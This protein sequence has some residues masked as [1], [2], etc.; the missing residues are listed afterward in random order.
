[1][2]IGVFDSGIGG[3]TVLAELRKKFPWARFV[4]LGDTANV[5]YGTKSPAQVKKLSVEC[6]KILSERQVHAAVIACNTASS[7]AFDEIQNQFG[8]TPVY[9]VLKPG[10]QAIMEAVGAK[11]KD[12]V[13]IL[14]TKATIRSQGYVKALKQ[15]DPKLNILEQACPL[16]VPMIEEGWV[17]HPILHQTIEEYVRPHLAKHKT[18]VALLACTHYPWV[19]EAFQ[20]A[21]PKWK[22]I[23]SAEAVAWAMEHDQAFQDLRKN[24]VCDGAVRG[25]GVN[26]KEIGEVEWIFTDPEALPEFAKQAQAR[27]S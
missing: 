17:D 12:P 7:L 25:P 23:H 15:I 27:L 8:K 26:A 13:L 1:V 21:L 2:K 11:P 14:A 10:V 3:I 16:L 9:G 4:Y 19:L 18:G 24:L 20:K 22:V 5:P 6:A